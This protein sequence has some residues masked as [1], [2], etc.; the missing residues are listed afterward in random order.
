[1]KVARIWAAHDVR[2]EDADLPRPGADEDLVRV[3]AVGLCGSDL[4][5]FLEGGIGSSRLDRPLVL[6]H[7]FAGVTS[8]GRRVAIEPAVAC[9]DCELCHAGHPNLCEAVRFAGHDVDG[10]LQEA[11]AWP[12][13]CFFPLP[14]AISD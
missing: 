5:W 2:L 14:D 1:M 7:E 13:R 12:R 4:H 8:D 6:G 9:G 10:A 11:M 3:T